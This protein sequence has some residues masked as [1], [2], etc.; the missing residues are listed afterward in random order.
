MHSD[1]SS[2]RVLLAERAL[3]GHRKTYMEWLSKID[4]AEMFVLAPQNVGVEESH[5]F[6]FD[7]G[8]AGKSCKA[9][10]GWIFQMRRIVMEN[11]IDVV[12]I[13]DGDSITR[14]FGAGFR[15]IGAKRIVITYHHF[16]QGYL[17]KLSYRMMCYGKSRTCVGHTDAVCR[18]LKKSGISNVAQ[19]AYPAFEFRSI[20]SKNPSVCKR[21][22]GL[23]EE[24]PVIG[25]VGGMNKYKNIV[26][27]LN[28]IRDCSASFQLLL[29]GKV[30]D[31][32]LE[33][34]LQAVEPYKERVK[35]VL[36]TLTDEEYQEA[37]VASDIIY[38]LYG[39]DFDGAS[40]PLTDGVCAKKL[41]LS[42]KHGSLGEIVTQNLLGITAECDDRKD[43]LEQ[44]ELAISSA[45]KFKYSDTANRYRENLNPGRFIEKYRTIYLA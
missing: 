43:M 39:H 11:Q 21:K 16:F 35:L 34:I 36:R 3:D 8:T 18:A 44:T 15:Y 10:L 2:M 40:G 25:I 23:S 6:R 42:C 27:F 1:A 13:L 38:C 4:G 20:E 30:G 12:H 45:K 19:C 31:V 5:F 33:E 29:C 17:R 7:S 26:P 22:F 24:V 37:I 41:I 9:Y 32:T 28:T 14:Y